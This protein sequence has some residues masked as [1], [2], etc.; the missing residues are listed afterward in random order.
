M[1]GWV[2]E[3]PSAEVTDVLAEAWVEGES[4]PMGY[5]G[6]DTAGTGEGQC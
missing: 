5:L 4:T 3:G 1:P 2:R 6:T